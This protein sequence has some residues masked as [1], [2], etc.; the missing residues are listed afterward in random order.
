MQSDGS[1]F[2]RDVV[3]DSLNKVCRVEDSILDQIY[4]KQIIE[5][6]YFFIY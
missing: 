2:G 6:I 4:D 1:S 5:I 3:L